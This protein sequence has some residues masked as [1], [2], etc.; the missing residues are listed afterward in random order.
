MLSLLL[1]DR[2]R[3]PWDSKRREKN[4]RSI[5]IICLGSVARLLR[6]WSRKAQSLRL[7][8]DVD[9]LRAGQRR[10]ICRGIRCVDSGPSGASVGPAAQSLAV[11]APLGLWLPVSTTRVGVSDRRAQL[12]APTRTTSEDETQVSIKGVTWF[13]CA[14]SQ[15]TPTATQ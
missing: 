6:L 13:L 14:T 11:H 12:L 15:N 3:W 10:P 1:G 5:V 2:W 4:Q 7:P 8:A 9:A